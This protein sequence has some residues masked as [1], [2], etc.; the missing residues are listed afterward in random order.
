MSVLGGAR[1]AVGWLGFG[2]SEIG[3]QNLYS[4]KGIIGDHRVQKMPRRR[5]KTSSSVTH[6]RSRSMK[7]AQLLEW[8]AAR[9]TYSVRLIVTTYCVVSPRPR[10]KTSAPR[11]PPSA[12]YPLFLSCSKADSPRKT[13]FATDTTSPT[14]YTPPPRF[15]HLVNPKQTCD[16]C[17]VGK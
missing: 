2:G 17:W 14:Q 5:M 4:W 10:P 7:T 3:C 15:L 8:F 13:L 6:S 11:P 12:F 9:P 1:W 16:T